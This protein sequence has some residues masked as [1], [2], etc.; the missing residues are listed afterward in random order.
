MVMATQ[1]NRTSSKQSRLPEDWPR[2]L[3]F[4]VLVALVVGVLLLGAI[5]QV[6]PPATA[7]I[8]PAPAAPLEHEPPADL[9]AA[10]ESPPR[11]MGA[12]P[13][14]IRGA[15][16]LAAR[17]TADLARL[18]APGNGW[19]AQLAVLCDPARVERLVDRFGDRSAFHVLPL[20]HRD[21]A[22]FRIC[23]NRYATRDDARGA[24]D[25]PRELREIQR[26]PLPKSIAEVVE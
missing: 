17:A 2:L 10:S 6:D 3:S 19:T 16:R 8:E 11:A 14:P 26:R 20:M 21:D 23:W 1:S 15:D 22:C 4:A 18:A 25:L 12:N 9:V 24:A 7:T 5:L 13:P